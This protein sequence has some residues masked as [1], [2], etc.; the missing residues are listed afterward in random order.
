MQLNAEDGGNRKYIL[1]QLPEDLDE[2]LK[3]AS[4]K[5]AQTIKNGIEFLDS[6]KKPHFITE[7]GK[8]RIRRAAKKIKEG[9]KDKEGIENL[10]TGFRVLK[11]DT[12]N[13]RDVYYNPADIELNV[14]ENQIDNVKDDRNEYDL[15]FQVML[16]FGIELSSAL[17]EIQV[18]SGKYLSVADGFLCASF[19]DNIDTDLVKAMAK[20]KASYAIF[21]DSSFKRDSDRINLEQIFN[22]LSPNTEIKVI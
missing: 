22:E 4:G 18:A 11:L 13:M 8:E 7:L 9:Y 16:D 10:D 12:S 1:V 2:N 3:N 6:I 5:S 17:E 19:D 21:K 14:L 20:S 15:L